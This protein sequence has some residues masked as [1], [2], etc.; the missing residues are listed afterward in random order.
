MKFSVLASGSSG[1]ALYIETEHVRLLVD[2]G[3]SG[4]QIEKHLHTIGVDPA[5]L[6][7][8]LVTHEHSDHVKGVGV[9]ARRY[10]LPVYMNQPTW[11]SLPT[12]VGKIEDAYKNILE[13]GAALELGDLHI[14]SFPISHDA[15]EPI[16]LRVEHGDS[17][18]ALVTDLGY[19][20]QRLV[21]QID[22]V[23]TLIF[24]ANHDVEMLRMGP[25]P[26][27]VKRRIFSDVGHLSNEDAG[28]ALINI[29]HSNGED[30]YLA[31]LSRENNLI[32]LAELTV[33]NILHEAELKVGKDVHLHKTHPDR[34]T[35][36]RRVTPKR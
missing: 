36:L 28:D 16:G 29:L 35:P 2:A 1:N 18:L 27:N 30:V 34:P 5:S 19:V 14:E 17:S 20:N 12:N 22:G 13:T 32:E 31:H 7:A 25:Y 23:D 9:L 3:L 26:W 10:R 33:Q 21:N 15:A 24:E 4:K 8:I 6:T 11:E